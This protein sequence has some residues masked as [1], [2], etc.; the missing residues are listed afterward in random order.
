MSG[1]CC[2]VVWLFG[3]FVVWLFCCL[4]SQWR[5]AINKTTKQLNN[6]T[7][8]QLNHLRCLP[9]GMGLQSPNWCSYLCTSE[10]VRWHLLHTPRRSYLWLPLTI[11]LRSCL[12]ITGHGLEMTT[13]F[14]QF[15]LWIW[16]RLHSFLTVCTLLGL[17]LFVFV[18]PKV[19]IVPRIIIVITIMLLIVV[20]IILKVLWA[21]RLCF[22]LCE[23]YYL[24]WNW[25]V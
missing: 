13:V 14:P 8:K 6:Q 11:C 5:K 25:G 3:Y 4:S 1:S 22:T 18:L 16:R 21:L 9:Y 24:S 20:F 2:F 19:V 7:T 10:T 12:S 15:L 17:W 23:S